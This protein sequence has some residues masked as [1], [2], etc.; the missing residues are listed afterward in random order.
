MAKR[1]ARKRPTPTNGR[2][3]N[4]GWKSEYSDGCDARDNPELQP[5]CGVLPAISLPV[6]VPQWREQVRH[7]GA[8]V[9]DPDERWLVEAI[10]LHDSGVDWDSAKRQAQ[11]KYRVAVR[12]KFSPDNGRTF[13]EIARYWAKQD[14]VTLKE[15]LDNC[16]RSYGD[17]HKVKRAPLGRSLAFHEGMA[18]REV[19]VKTTELRRKQ[20]RVMYDALARELG[21]ESLDAYLAQP[22]A[23]MAKLAWCLGARAR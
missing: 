6:E 12:D 22:G 7:A 14:R 10:R 15:Y 13:Q 2:R 17:A 1:R 23:T 18:R 5:L 8:L 20:A 9:A 16:A 3:V 11:A 21:H 19:E 4:G